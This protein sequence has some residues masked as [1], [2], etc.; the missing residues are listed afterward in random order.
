MTPDD[1]PLQMGLVVYPRASQI[2]PHV[3]HP[4]ERRLEGTTEVILVRRGRCIVDFYT[5]EREHVRAVDLETGD[6]VMLLAS[7][8]HG[9]RLKDDTI[10][11][12]VKQGPYVG[13]KD[14]ERFPGAFPNL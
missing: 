2:P 10:L 11:F 7:G 12:E 9:F 6:I 4:V 5:Q 8:G 14:K 3:H 1:A 13:E